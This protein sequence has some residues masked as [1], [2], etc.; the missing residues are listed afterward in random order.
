[1]II[2]LPALLGLAK[3]LT[4]GK[5][6]NRIE[7]PAPR[8]VLRSVPKWIAVSML[9]WTA[10]GEAGSELWYRIHETKLVPTPR[11]S[12][13]WPTHNPRF[14][15][16]TVPQKALSILRCSDSDAAEW[17]DAAGNQWSGFLLR[18]KAGKNSAQLAKGH[19]P[20]VC[21]PAA[22]ARLLEDQGQLT[23]RISDFQIPFRTE[24]FEIGNKTV[25]VFYCL[26]PD[27]ISLRQG[28]LLED[29]SQWSR[30][31]AVLAGK[32]NL[33]QQVLELVVS[34]PD[35]AAEAANTLREALPTLIR[36][37]NPD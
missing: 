13:V 23:V 32:R 14:K 3:V 21:F 17:E 16:T 9:I 7:A 1:M 36:P 37:A 31:E 27:R 33:G 24:S 19:R 12:A 26:W 4:S 29:G 20:E 8:S 5:P 25:Y 30:V 22:G 35:S 10:L 18:W 6:A 28:S 2:V 34:G 11:W 15:A